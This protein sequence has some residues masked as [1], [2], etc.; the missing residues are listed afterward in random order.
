MVKGLQAVEQVRAV[1]LRAVGENAFDAQVQGNVAVLMNRFGFMA[2][3]GQGIGKCLCRNAS[4][5][6]LLY[7]A[8]KRAWYARVM[9]YRNSLRQMPGTV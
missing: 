9:G 4:G 2:R 7:S 8:S 6:V 5:K 3:G 1:E